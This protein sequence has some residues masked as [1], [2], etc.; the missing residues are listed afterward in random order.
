MN[1]ATYSRRVAAEP[2]DLPDAIQ[3][4]NRAP[5]ATPVT[6]DCG[7]D[8]CAGWYHPPMAA[9]RD[10]VVVLCPPIGHE[11]VSG[12][13][14]LVQ[15][16]THLAQQGFPVLRFDYHGTGDSAGTDADP[17]RVA[18]WLASVEAAVAQARRLSLASHVALLGIRLGAVLALEVAARSTVGESLVLWAPCPSGRSFVR[19]LRM[20]GFEGP[21]GSVRA[22]GYWYSADTLRDLTALD[23][24][25]R[26][27][28]AV[29]RVLLVARDDLQLER[30][31]A[32]ALGKSGAEV[33][34][35]VLPGYSAMLQHGRLP[36]RVDQRL[37]DP[38]SRWLMESPHA[39]VLQGGPLPSPALESRCV[40]N[41][42]DTP[43]R[44]G[45]DSRI[46]GV[47]SEPA[48]GHQAGNGKAVV[49]LNAG[50]AYRI[51]PHRMYVK[52]ARALAYS[53]YRVLRMDL[54]GVGD[55]D[56]EEPAR[57]APELYAL[58]SVEDVRCAID[59]LAVR[60]HREFVLAGLC[61]GAYLAFQASLQDSRV[62]GVVLMNPRLLQWTPATPGESWETSRELYPKPV[63]AYGRALLRLSV[64]RRLL[65][66]DVSLRWLVQRFASLVAAHLGRL[67]M[68]ALP[69]GSPLWKMRR[70]CH[71]GASVL[72]LV[73]D[74]DESRPYVEFHFGRSGKLLRSQPRFRVADI[75]DADHTFT[76]PGNVDAVLQRILNYL[77]H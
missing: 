42:R 67:R 76:R 24:G 52:L 36:G 68:D 38:I 54:A 19:E 44:F 70:L 77:R 59:W 3:P 12:Y 41:V 33:D 31:L 4:A 60:G 49:L 8:W 26:P 61:S 5:R 62:S 13:A 47:L 22:Q 73:A 63:R 74:E 40:G 65:A 2:A 6:I 20:G 28:G 48:G 50:H 14:I 45:K 25:E 10:L 1:T 37:L 55:S 30:P 46:F 7:E 27:L 39:A 71:R 35:R 9:A 43:V 53:G 69:E 64:W 57:G 56:P 23:P 32:A 72:L 15:L 29:R 66:G 34:F 75:H 18:A 21:D 17:G 11:A 51:G 58:K 16:A